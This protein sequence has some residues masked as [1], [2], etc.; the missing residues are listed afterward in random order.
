MNSQPSNPPK[1]RAGLR[2]LLSLFTLTGCIL[3]VAGL[4]VHYWEDLSLPISFSR[5]T[6]EPTSTIQPTQPDHTPTPVITSSPTETFTPT[7][8]PYTIELNPKDQAEMVLIAAGEFTMGS[9]AN[10]DL[11]FWGA[12]GPAHAVLLDS[13]LIY[14]TEVTNAMYQVC[15]E[16]KACP[17]PAQV[18]SATRADYFQNPQYANHPVIYVSW[19]GALAYC[20]WADAKLPTEAQ[21]EKAARGTDGRLFPWGDNTSASA[22]A[23]FASQDTVVTGNY[24]QG[25][26]PYGVLDMAGNVLEWV[27]DRFQAGYYSLSPY[28]NPIGPAGTDRR[29]IRGGAWHHTDL[30]ALRVVARASLK[31]S[32]TGNDIGFRC[33]VPSP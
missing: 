5:P 11:Y 4:G 19:V 14:R 27:N 33:V 6:D 24:P 9:D 26:S 32:Y 13:F 29:V 12:E 21:W 8:V 10:T 31:E 30:S 18:F 15:V 2:I 28:E 20:Q 1:D 23:N 7:P 17:R 16:A 22:L 25:V 3:M